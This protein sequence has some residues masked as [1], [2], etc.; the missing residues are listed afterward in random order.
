MGQTPPTNSKPPLEAN[1]PLK[2]QDR[3]KPPLEGILGMPET[4]LNLGGGG[5]YDD[6]LVSV[7]RV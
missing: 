3:V 2:I 5:R 1:P 7:V 4:P 6:K